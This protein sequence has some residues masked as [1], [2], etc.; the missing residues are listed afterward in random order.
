MQ[1]DTVRVWDPLVRVFHWTLVLAFFTAYL[2]E[3][4]WLDLHTLAGYTVL[5]LVAFRLLWG[6]I[7]T[8]HARFVDF[9]RRPREVLVYVKEVLTL[10]PRRYLGHNPAGGLMIVLLLVSLLATTGFGLA[11]YAAEEGA[12]PLAGMLAGVSESTGHLFEEVHEFFANFT[13][14]LVAVHVAGV[15]VESLLHGE[16]LVRSMVTGRKPAQPE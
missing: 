3:D 2:T 15:I 5:G 4:D 8:R 1:T 11:V 13:L 12:G 7:G 14:F 9:V 6:L 10:H 16:N